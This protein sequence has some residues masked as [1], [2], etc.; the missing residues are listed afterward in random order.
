MNL[1]V[2]MCGEEKGEGE[3][4]IITAGWLSPLSGSQQP[5]RGK[6]A[7]QLGPRSITEL[8]AEE[9]PRKQGPLCL[10]WGW[11]IETFHH[12]V[13]MARGFSNQSLRT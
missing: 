1:W 2:L 5:P 3:T 9:H 8:L 13:G 6:S 12:R 7:L 11:G 4:K 10:L